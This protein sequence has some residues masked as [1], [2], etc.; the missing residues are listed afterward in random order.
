MGKIVSIDN[1]EFE[2]YIHHQD[3]QNR[4]L[5][6][7]KKMEEKYEALN[8]IFLVVMNGAF[9]FAADLLREIH[10][11]SETAFIRIKSYE[12]THSTGVVNI[13]LPEHA[14]ISGRHV[15][16]MEDIVDTGNSMDALLP[17]LKKHHPAS[18][19]ITSLLFKPE[20]LE[21]DVA[22]DFPGF[23]IPK[24]F[25]VG[26]GLDYNEKG[27]NLKDIYKLKS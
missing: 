23:V 8:P 10:F 2:V 20:A 21:H 7:A 26:Y 17:E 3:I 12:G 6:L 9:I 22:V 19:A 24:Y 11:P 13:S 15:I 27:R 25:V 14:D 16:I 5:A 4:I 1:L 18:I